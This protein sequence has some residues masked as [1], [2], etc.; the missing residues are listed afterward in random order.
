MILID[1]TIN[2]QTDKAHL[3][4][5][6][7]IWTGTKLFRFKLCLSQNHDVTHYI[8]FQVFSMGKSSLKDSRSFFI[9][10]LR[11]L[12]WNTTFFWPSTNI[13]I[14]FSSEHVLLELIWKPKNYIKRIFI[15][16]HNDDI[17]SRMP[18]QLKRL[19]E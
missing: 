13:I 6:P 8:E 17:N 10:M 1:F 7:D 18:W 11:K 2:K 16:L 15:F 12:F 3:N 4:L 19:I 14:Q 5:S 9:I